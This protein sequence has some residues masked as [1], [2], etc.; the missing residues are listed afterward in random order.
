[1]CTTITDVTVEFAMAAYTV[2]ESESSIKIVVL[3]RV[4]G[5]LP[6]K[7]V[8]N[9]HIQHS[10]ILY[11]LDS[12]MFESSENKSLIISEVL[13]NISSKSS[14]ISIFLVTMTTEDSLV[15]LK[16]NTVVP[17]TIIYVPSIPSNIT[18][19][20]K[21]TSITITWEQDL[22]S[23]VHQYELRYTFTIKECQNNNGEVWNVTI[24]GY[25]RNYTITDSSI[26]PVEEDS[27][28]TISFT[29][30]NSVGKSEALT[31]ETTTE[32]TGLYSYNC[33]TCLY[34]ILTF[35]LI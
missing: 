4:F 22:H 23:D 1:M 30:V 35:C 24:D 5:S 19:F 14:G 11:L 33:L 18:A 3:G 16:G 8:V 9:F 13:Y 27:D 29:A 7:A 15:E 32:E 34:Y 26:T 10:D 6:T 21:S 2:L 31:I 12:L 28:Y 17:V 20:P 25:K